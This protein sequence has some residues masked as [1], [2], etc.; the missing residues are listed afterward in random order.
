VI[1]LDT[2]I[3]V[4]A[5]RRDSEWH[6]V[7]KKSVRLL[8][9]G[10]ENWAIAWP[11]IHEF[12][13]IVSH[14]RIYSPPSSI[15]KALDQVLAWLESPNLT[16]LSEGEGYVEVLGKLIRGAKIIGPRI[17][18]ARIAALCLSWN[19]TEL[20]TADRDFG[21]FPSLRTRN[22]LIHSK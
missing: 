11:S 6:E 21:R 16:L 2:N 5:H 18:D 3:L 4:Y 22:P 8:A 17:H 12:L 20:W 19:V 15:E 14:E 7:A 1:A 10:V 9:E 13:A